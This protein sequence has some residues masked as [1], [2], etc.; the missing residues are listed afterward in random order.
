M[1]RIS[2]QDLHKEMLSASDYPE[3]WEDLD[4][5]QQA[6]FVRMAR[7]LNR[8]ADGESV[9][10]LPTRKSLIRQHQ[11]D[12]DELV[13]KPLR[14]GSWVD[15]FLEQS[16][17]Q[18]MIQY[19]KVAL[20]YLESGGDIEATIDALSSEELEDMMRA[21]GVFVCCRDDIEQEG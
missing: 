11:R 6:L 15:R 8:I 17:D 21:Q 10:R 5:E 14:M 12:I 4:D 2:P 13:N 18:N 19:H 20:N 16:V 1:P 3:D 7:N 9:R